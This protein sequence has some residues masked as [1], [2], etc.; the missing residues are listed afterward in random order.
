MAKVLEGMAELEFKNTSCILKFMDKIRSQ[1]DPQLRKQTEARLA[2]VPIEERLLDSVKGGKMEG[3][4]SGYYLYE[5]FQ[6][7]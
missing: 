7:S 5:G 3:K 2:A 6:S 4:G 1:I